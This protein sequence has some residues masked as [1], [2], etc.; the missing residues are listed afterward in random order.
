MRTKTLLLSAA[1]G[2][3]GLLAADA[4]VY[5]VNSVGYINLALPSGFSMIANQLDNGNGNLVP[6][7]LTVP[8]GTTIF[9][10][11][12]STGS[13]DLNTFLFGG[14]DDPQMTLSPGEGAFINN[15]SGGVINL[16]FVGEVSQGNLSN[17]LPAGF[18]LK[19]SQVPQAG[20]LAADLAFPA[21]DGDVVF[22]F[23]NASGAYETST[24]LFGSWT[25]SAPAVEVGESFFVNKQVA[26]SWDRTFSV[27]N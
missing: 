15:A 5:S 25:P 23:S 24:F 4:Q 9:K 27:N 3:V 8:D 22:T 2:A 1:V 21:D 17:P 7:I 10:Y 12:E 14:W 16:T 26:G 11:N 6:D 18:S 20:D 13:Y 19:S